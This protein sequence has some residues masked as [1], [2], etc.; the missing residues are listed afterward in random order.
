MFVH[1]CRYFEVYTH[2]CADRLDGQTDR[3]TDLQRRIEKINTLDRLDT[4]DEL[5]GLDSIDW[6][7]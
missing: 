7:D 4:L 1:M 2:T 6:I 5:D 3:Q